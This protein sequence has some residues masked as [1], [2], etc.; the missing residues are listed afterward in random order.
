VET[1]GNGHN[2][3]L[4]LPEARQTKIEACCQL[5]KRQAARIQQLAQEAAEEAAKATTKTEIAHARSKCTALAMAS[6]AFDLMRARVRIEQGKPDPAPFKSS[7]DRKP[8]RQREAP[9]PLPAKVS[10][11]PTSAV[12]PPTT[13]ADQHPKP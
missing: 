5:A 3:L 13:P 12:S 2:R 11:Q 7:E 8:R 10:A 6:K 9:D 1:N 4:T